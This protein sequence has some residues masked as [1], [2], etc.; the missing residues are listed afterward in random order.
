LHVTRDAREHGEARC[1]RDEVLWVSLEA[2]TLVEQI[3]ALFADLWKRLKGLGIGKRE[4][5]RSED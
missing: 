4:E 1:A 5:K 2:V 3:M